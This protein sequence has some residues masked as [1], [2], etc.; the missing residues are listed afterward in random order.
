MLA[1][2]D[3]QALGRRLRAGDGRP[4]TQTETL[5][6]RAL[7]RDRGSSVKWLA[8]RM[9]VSVLYASRT[10]RRLVAGAYVRRTPTGSYILARA[11]P[12]IVDRVVSL[13]AKRSEWK[14]ALLQARAHQSFATEAYVVFDA[15][16][17]KRFK[18]VA[19]YFRGLGIGLMA[20][21]VVGGGFETLVRSRRS[22]LWSR[23][24]H[25]I[26]SERTL[27]RLIGSKRPSSP[28]SNLPGA[29]RTTSGPTQPCWIGPSSRS[30]A[31][32]QVARATPPVR[33]RRR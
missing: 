30:L 23:C 9:H 3:R 12:L 31:R 15:H 29:L 28:Q 5:A 16:Y 25:H 20:L 17:R 6:V 24:G 2:V 14:D 7:R 13:E 21:S 26:S 32:L 33:A 4:L 27:G 11:V 19:E 22:Q 1:R 10:L 18:E 8:V